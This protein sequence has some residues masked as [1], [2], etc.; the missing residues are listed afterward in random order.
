MLCNYV[1][2]TED[3]TA[4]RQIMG[5]SAKYYF[6][7]FIVVT[8]LVFVTLSAAFLSDT[9][10]ASSGPDPRVTNVE[11]DSG[12]DKVTVMVNNNGEEGEVAV[13]TKFLDVNGNT[14]LTERKKVVIDANMEEEVNIQ[15]DIPEEVDEIKASTVPTTAVSETVQELGK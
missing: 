3:D 1:S 4:V 7:A 5:I 13:R 6:S 14:V 8:V 10:T 15:V 2:M 11:A 9:S 12:L